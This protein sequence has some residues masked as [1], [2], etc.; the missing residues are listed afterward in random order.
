MLDREGLKWG[1]WPLIMLKSAILIA[2]PL[3]LV[4]LWPLLCV[5]PLLLLALVSLPTPVMNLGSL[6]FKSADPKLDVRWN[7][8]PG[9]GLLLYEYL[10]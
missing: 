6:L 4:V 5:P 3:L 1:E 8:R 9:L 10:V 2:D 7:R